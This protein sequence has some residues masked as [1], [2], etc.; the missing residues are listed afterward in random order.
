MGHGLSGSLW[1]GSG[2]SY[3]SAA[4]R[5]QSAGARAS[6]GRM[7]KIL[8]P[9]NF[10]DAREDVENWDRHPETA[11]T[12]SP[13]LP[14]RLQRRRLPDPRRAQA[15]PPAAR[16][17]EARDGARRARHRLDDRDARQR[18]HPRPGARRQRPR[19]PGLAR[20]APYYEQARAF[21]R[22]AT[23]QRARH[24]QPRERHLHRR[25]AR[26]HGGRQ[27]RRRR[28]R[29]HLGQPQH[30]AAARAG[31]EPLGHARAQLQLPLLRRAQDALPD[32]RARDRG[33]PGRLRHP[34]RALR[35]ADAGA[36]RPHGAACRSCSSAR[37]SGSG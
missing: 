12:R 17:P 24:R 23:E 35:G 32:A 16:A 21:A 20:L 19:T 4:P 2:A 1:R 33:V 14:A 11:Q 5:W 28:G 34:R 9:R 29:R 8:E 36:D 27:P 26:D 25:R 31:A 37:P 15:G 22:L 10:P 18:P 13:S 3:K 6:H 30:R 7:K